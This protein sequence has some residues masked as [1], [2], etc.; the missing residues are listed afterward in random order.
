MAHQPPTSDFQSPPR[1]AYVHIPFCRA[2][3]HYCDFNSY[4]GM[5]GIFDDYAQALIDEISRALPAS[6]PLDS[7]YF[8]GGTP[9]VLPA[10]VLAAILRTME[11]RFGLAADA[12]IT[13]EANPGTVDAGYLWALRGCGFNRLSVGVQSFE[14]AVLARIGRIHTVREGRDAVVGA[15][16]AGFDNVSIDL[17]FGL[18]DQSASGWR[19]DLQ[20]A[21]ELS[22]EHI[23]LYELTIE[24]GTRFGDLQKRCLLKLPDEDEQIEMYEMAIEALTAAGFEHYEVSNFARPGR[25]SRHNQTYWRNEP[26]FGFGAGATAYLGGVR[27][28]NVRSPVDYIERIRS[29]GSAVESAETVVGRQ[30]MGETI[31]L[32]LRM[33]DGVELAAF[34][35]RFGVALPDVY[36]KEIA[37]LT[38][39]GLIQLT[40]TR[41]KLTPVGVLLAN[42]AAAEFL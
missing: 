42:E 40:D 24:E 32:G 28:A 5:E 14:D 10:G 39:R 1:A 18:P 25:R 19:R 17:M 31:M 13:A 27:S 35:S 8:G 16:V 9:T 21:F 11:E 29:T 4:A 23:S 20:S 36:R 26:Y 30:A 22:P 33:L 12:E 38:L 37:S 2:K 34:Q 6:T 41:I 15:R 7:V 3:C